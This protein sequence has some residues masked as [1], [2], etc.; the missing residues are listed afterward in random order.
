VQRALYISHLILN[1]PIHGTRAYAFKYVIHFISLISTF[2]PWGEYYT[3]HSSNQEC[4]EYRLPS[5]SIRD[6]VR[7]ADHFPHPKLLNG[8]R[9]N[10]AWGT[11]IKIINMYAVKL[12]MVHINRFGVTYLI[13]KHNTDKIVQCA[14]ETFQRSQTKSIFASKQLDI[15]TG[16][17]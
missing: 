7:T 10:L 15:C 8:F 14:K 3:S 12:C 4:T 1:S 11:H 17:T 2:L 13:R 9:I 16:T 6:Y 5:N